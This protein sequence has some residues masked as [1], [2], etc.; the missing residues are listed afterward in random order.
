MSDRLYIANYASP[1]GN[2]QITATD[3]IHSILFDKNSGE[4]VNDAQTPLIKKCIGQL[5]EFFNGGRKSFDLPLAPEGTPFQKSVWQA[6]QKI[7]YGKTISYLALAIELGDEKTVRAVGAANGKNPI[8]IVIP[9][10][11]VIGM[12]HKLVGYAGGLWRKQWLLEHEE[13]FERGVLRLF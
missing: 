2:L 12:N 1:V 13:K 4:N 10:H 8:A 11:R 7:P 9:C 5:D 6:L 3:A